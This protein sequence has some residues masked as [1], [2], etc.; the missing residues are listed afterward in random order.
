MPLPSWTVFFTPD[1]SA[2]RDARRLARS[3]ESMSRSESVEKGK[4]GKKKKDSFLWKGMVEPIN[5]AA[6]CS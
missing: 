5:K 2:Q 4:E 1:P 3:R 6:V